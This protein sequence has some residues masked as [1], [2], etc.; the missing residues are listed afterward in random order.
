MKKTYRQMMLESVKNSK[1][2]EGVLEDGNNIV[3][4]SAYVVN[5]ILCDD[6]GN[7]VGSI[8]RR[9]DDNSEIITMCE[10]R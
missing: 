2:W 10:F 4:W 5:T 3:Y 6:E 1:I 9:R 7:K 8:T